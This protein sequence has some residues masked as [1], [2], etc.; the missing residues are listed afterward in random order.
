MVNKVTVADTRVNLFAGLE[1]Q[2]P[3]IVFTTL[4]LGKYLVCTHSPL[5]H[6]P[7]TPLRP[8]S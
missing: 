7:L 8:I 6:T 2:L 4:L 5:P 1:L 3:I